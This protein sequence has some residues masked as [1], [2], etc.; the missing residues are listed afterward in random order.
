[1]SSLAPSRIALSASLMLVGLRNSSVSLVSL[2]HLCSADTSV[3]SP[4]TTILLMSRVPSSSALRPSTISSADFLP[5][6]RSMALRRA[7]TSS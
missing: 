6:M 1:M 4:S 5:K 7:P 3:V 2:A